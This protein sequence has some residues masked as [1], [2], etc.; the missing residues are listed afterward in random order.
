MDRQV[1]V[2][3]SAPPVA[4]RLAANAAMAGY[5]AL[6]K[7]LNVRMVSKA[8]RRSTA[9]AEERIFFARDCGLA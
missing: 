3:V 9:A 1:P 7:L 4:G 2:S 8:G 6:D 5:T